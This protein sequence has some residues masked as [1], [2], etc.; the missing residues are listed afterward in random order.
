MGHEY[1]LFI[2]TYNSYRLMGYSETRLVYD[3]MRHN[4]TSMKYLSGDPYPLASG[5][6]SPTGVMSHEWISCK[7]YL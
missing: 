5:P 6:A 7:E 1:L 2:M 4:D 3:N